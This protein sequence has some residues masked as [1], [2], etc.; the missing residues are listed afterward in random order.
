MRAPVR[1]QHRLPVPAMMSNSLTEVHAGNYDSN[2]QYMEQEEEWEREGLLR[3]SLGKAAAKGQSSF[4]R[5]LFSAARPCES[6]IV[7][8]IV[9]AH[10]V[11]P[12]A[13]SS[14]LPR[15]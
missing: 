6:L 11:R 3:P 13:A 10:F 1:Q 7:M 14:P 9:S 5:F 15:C 12:S 8:D 2:G 4:F